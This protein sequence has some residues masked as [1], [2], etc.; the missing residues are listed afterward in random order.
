MVDERNWP[1]AWN[2][3]RDSAFSAFGKIYIP[4][5]IFLVLVVHLNLDTPECIGFLWQWSETIARQLYTVHREILFSSF[6]LN[7]LKIIC[8]HIKFS[9]FHIEIQTAI[10]RWKTLL[11]SSPV[12]LAFL[13]SHWLPGK[14]DSSCPWRRTSRSLCFNPFLTTQASKH[15]SVPKS[16]HLMYSQPFLF[17]CF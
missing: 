1:S 6:S 10:F 9:R 14:A 12:A 11:P 16:C 7:F 8:L 5:G 4:W 3:L 13:E 17:E 15:L 2:I